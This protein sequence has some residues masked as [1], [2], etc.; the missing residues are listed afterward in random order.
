M[1][2]PL[3]RTG[4]LRLPR[5]APVPM[6]RWAP[7]L[8]IALVAGALLASSTAVTPP[9]DFLAAER[10]LQAVDAGTI[11]T[12][13][14]PMQSEP[15]QRPN[16]RVGVYG[17]STA[18]MT[19]MGVGDWA[20]AKPGV[21]LVSGVSRLG[22][23]VALAA[24]RRLL[25]GSVGTVGAQCLSWPQDWALQARANVPNVA[26]VQVGPWDILDRRESPSEP[27]T[28]L[29]DADTRALMLDEL[30]MAVDILNTEGALVVWLTGPKPNARSQ[31]PDHRLLATGEE[32]WRI[33]TFNDLVRDLPRLRPGGVEV[34]E[35]A[36]WH[37][38]IGEQEDERLRPDGVHL[39][40]ETSLEVAS[41]F[42]GAE[43]D[44]IIEEALEDG[45]FDDLTQASL[46]RTAGAPPLSLVPRGAPLRVVVW[47]DTRAAEI[48]EV[49]PTTI[50]D[51]VVDV[52]VVAEPGCAV[53]RLDRRGDYPS[54][55]DRPNADCVEGT[56]IAQA[57][58]DH[59]PQVVVIAADW[60]VDLAVGDID[61]FS[62]WLNSELS[63]AV[64]GLRL[65]GARVVVVNLPHLDPEGSFGHSDPQIVNIVWDVLTRS[66]FRRDWMAI[67]DVRPGVD[68][69]PP[70]AI[71][72]AIS[73]LLADQ[74]E[75][76]TR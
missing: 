55:Q 60:P 39:S 66:P 56:S 32:G 6:V 36:A 29:G 45:R 19:A 68:L 57:V 26:V 47:G 35:L 40:M 28:N 1:E 2:K 22:C 54:P 24:E 50:D 31:S 61:P 13:L 71:S 63:R 20:T 43:L 49:M 34:V 70:E 8:S 15:G 30:L 51:H 72:S 58:A 75:R 62:P 5:L 9:I 38:S 25:A 53:G 27:F 76:T 67:A 46:A 16:V 4:R 64:D 59:D 69:A 37:D 23:G 11:D 41:R 73:G 14:P 42:L 7:P 18:L 12:A 33:E 65:T 17:D 48:A 10:Q 3:R 52:V 74:T 21:E 44:R